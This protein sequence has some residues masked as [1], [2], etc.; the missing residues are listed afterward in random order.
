MCDVLCLTEVWD[1]APHKNTDLQNMRL[2]SKNT[3]EGRGGGV[4]IYVGTDFD[5][6]ETA[7]YSQEGVEHAAIKIKMKQG[8]HEIHCIYRR[9]ADNPEALKNVLAMITDNSSSRTTIVGDMNM[10]WLGHESKHEKWRDY[11]KAI[12][13]KN[14]V[15]QPTR[16]GKDRD[17][18]LDHV[19]V[20]H[21]EVSTV[22]TADLHLADHLAVKVSIRDPPPKKAKTKSKLT[23]DTSEASVALLRLHLREENWDKLYVEGGLLNNN[24]DK[25]NDTLAAHVARFC[26]KKVEFRD[27]IPP[28][29]DKEYRQQWTKMATS[30]KA[31]AKTAPAT[32]QREEAISKYNSIKK[33]FRRM[34][35]KKKHEYYR[36]KLQAADSKET[37]KILNEVLHR[38]K[39]SHS[40]AKIEVDGIEITEDEEIAHRLNKFYCNIG[41]KLA[42]KIEATGISP[43]DG[44]PTFNGP[45]MHENPVTASE[46]VTEAKKLQNKTSHSY[47][48]L[49]NKLFKMI[50]PEITIPLTRLVRD[51]LATG[52]I[53][54]AIKKA[55]AIY[56]KK[57]P[58]AKQLGDFRPISLVPVL[59]KIIDKIY[60]S[61]LNKHMVQHGLW[62][63]EQHGYL[64]TKSTASAL[65]EVMLRVQH[66]VAQGR[67]TVLIMLDSS[68]A[69]DTVEPAT[70]LEKAEKY[71]VKGPNLKFMNNYVEGRSQVSLVA[72]SQSTE[73]EKLIG[74]PQG[75]NLS[76][77]AFIMYNNDLPAHVPEA[78]VTM[79]SDDTSLVISAPTS[80]ALEQTANAIL[81][82]VGTWFNTSKLTLN[83]DKSNYITYGT[84][85]K[86][87]LK[88]TK[89][90]LQHITTGTAKLL[91]VDLQPDGKY[92]AHATKIQGRIAKAAAMLR[93][94]KNLMP[95]HL[96]IMVYRSLLESHLRYALPLWGPTL[97]LAD[98]KKFETIQKKALRAVEGAPYNAHTNPIFKK[99]N[100]LKF[101][102]LIRTEMQM[103]MYDATYGNM[104]PRLTAF[105]TGT[106][107]TRREGLRGGTDLRQPRTTRD[108]PLLNALRVTWNIMDGEQR[109]EAS[110]KSLKASLV[111]E[112]IDGYNIHCND[113]A[114]WDCFGRKLH[115]EKE[116]SRKMEIALRTLPA[117]DILAIT[118]KKKTFAMYGIK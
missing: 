90:K 3:R 46:L 72:N 34:Q 41:Q 36:M 11:I 6:E 7:S 105:L 64:K 20:T 89:S 110:R 112:A 102:D 71:G 86:V 99:Y 98:I 54:K 77:L 42:D 88:M 68:K 4:A 73:E 70:L 40:I 94:I 33:D 61:R 32:A 59:M 18:C 22:E 114:C 115:K 56:L 30:A 111:R 9:P 31:K 108:P 83:Q 48:M 74:V 39:Q 116:D 19:Y 92:A 43:G 81:D 14:V 100:V 76:C 109:R 37:W 52:E 23:L 49:S 80:R 28:W 55:N 117:P 8:V 82:T 118:S 10:D 65:L 27:N 107:H 17:S 50:L 53:P 113:N 1:I 66:E 106:D 60:S 35:R 75:G 62:A 96:K 24:F 21:G 57:K 15:E 5:V 38:G 45:Y 63:D 25:F 51:V 47:D 91:G 103:L 79:Y 97:S 101:S 16:L 84:K 13:L 78:Y 29:Q 2:A 95:K 87:T 67:P 69:F 93:E 58:H 85:D 104:P 26:I 12:G 44:W